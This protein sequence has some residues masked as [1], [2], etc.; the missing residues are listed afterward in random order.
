MRPRP[1]G[2]SIRRRVLTA[3]SNDPLVMA[4][5][6]YYRAVTAA[7]ERKPREAAK[8]AEMADAAFSR[9]LPPGV[10]SARL[11]L[12]F[13]T[14]TV[15]SRGIRPGAADPDPATTPTEQTAILGLAETLRLRSALAERAG[16]S[17]EASELGARGRIVAA[18]DRAGGFEHRGALASPGREQPADATDYRAAAGYSYQAGGVFERVVPGERPQAINMLRQGA[19]RLQQGRTNEALAL[20]GEAGQIL[21]RPGVVGASPEDISLGSTPS[22]RA[23]ERD[24]EDRPQMTTEMFEAAQL[25][26]GSR[27]ALDIAQATARLAAG[28]PKTARC[29]SRLPGQAR[30]LDVVKRERDVAVADRALP[31]ASPRSMPGSRG[32]EGAG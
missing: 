6:D 8:W 13:R 9:L 20:F 10:G 31:T 19:Y 25:A 2:C 27:T 15:K 23:G 30:E 4:Q 14:S 21:R 29:H 11:V 12:N 22:Y 24:P 28:D 26:M 32:A 3:R 1:I 16:H 18:I 5:L 17:A 7:Y